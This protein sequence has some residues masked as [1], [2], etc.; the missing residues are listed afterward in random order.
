MRKKSEGEGRGAESAGEGEEGI[1]SVRG[2]G[3]EGERGKK[4][5][6]HEGKND[7][8]ER[9]GVGK[10]GIAGEGEGSGKIWDWKSCNEG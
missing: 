1:K 6:R 2:G 9:N 10:R 3:M 5:L 8:G 4:W 7:G